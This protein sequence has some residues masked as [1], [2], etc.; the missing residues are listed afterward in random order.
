MDK[1]GHNEDI[2][3]F[4]IID[5]KIMKEMNIPASAGHLGRVNVKVV[6]NGYTKMLVISDSRQED[7]WIED[8]KNKKEEANKFKF[9]NFEFFDQGDDHVKQRIMELSIESIMV[10][11]IHRRRE[12][13]SFFISKIRADLEEISE[14]YKIKFAIGYIQLDN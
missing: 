4:Q 9:L 2:N 3:L 14:M 7:D 6:T 12:L 8:E 13:M 10:S 5:K 1:I 11:M